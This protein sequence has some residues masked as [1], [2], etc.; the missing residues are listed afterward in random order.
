MDLN[1]GSRVQHR[2]RCRN[3]AVRATEDCLEVT[4]WVTA[5]SLKTVYLK[6]TLLPSAMLNWSPMSS[7]VNGESYNLGVPRKLIQSQIQLI[8]R[9]I[10]MWYYFR[11]NKLLQL[12]KFSVFHW[13]RFRILRIIIIIIINKNSAFRVFWIYKNKMNIGQN[14][15]YGFEREHFNELFYTKAFAKTTLTGKSCWEKERSLNTG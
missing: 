11:L 2:S 9:K 8:N 4:A 15:I 1:D 14:V 5:V 12:V 3:F 13:I 7:M 10:K 6:A